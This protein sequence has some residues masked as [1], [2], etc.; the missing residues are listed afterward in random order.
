MTNRTI[1][2]RSLMA[3]YPRLP[4]MALYPRLPL[5]ALTP[6]LLTAC[7]TQPDVQQLRQENAQLEQEVEQASD[8]ISEFRVREE[9]LRAELEERKRI[10]GVLRTEKSSR[11]EESTELRGLVREFVQNQIDS[12]REFLFQADL[13]DYVGGELVSRSQR[14]D[15]ALTLVDLAHPIPKAGT[16]TGVAGY[17]EASGEVAVS[18]LRPVGEELVVV[19]RSPPVVIEQSGEVRAS[20]PVTVGV[21]PGDLLAYEFSGPVPVG[22][23]RGTGNT[24]FQR[25]NLTVGSTINPDNLKGEEESRSYSLGVFG[26]LN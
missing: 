10:I 13:L 26:L 18:V 21:E 9:Q 3:L 15:E 17:F 6:L 16:L 22:F 19:W 7:A 2:R 23:D 8:Q 1:L 12:Y 24:R 14:G 20:F 5:M 4:L 25:A 11:V